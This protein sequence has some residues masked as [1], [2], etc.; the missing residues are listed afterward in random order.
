MLLQQSHIFNV[1]GAGSIPGGG[2]NILYATI[3]KR[4]P[5][6]HMDLIDLCREVKISQINKQS[7]I[8]DVKSLLMK[9]KEKSEKAGFSQHSDN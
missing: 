4:K 2:T 9:V 1:G 7:S 6:V 5:S 3:K 8:L